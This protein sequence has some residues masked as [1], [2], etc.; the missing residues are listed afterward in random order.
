VDDDQAAVLANEAADLQHGDAVAGWAD[1]N[2][3]LVVALVREVEDRVAQ[4]VSEVLIRNSVFPRGGEDLERSIGGLT[5]RSLLTA[6]SMALCGGGPG[7]ASQ[8]WRT[9]PSSSASISRSSRWPVGRG[10]TRRRPTPST[11]TASRC[12]MSWRTSR[13]PRTAVGSRRGRYTQF[14][15]PRGAQA[16]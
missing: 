11:R 10:A 13:T 7:S 1:G 12:D 2:G 15:R 4:R 6:A 8:P 14:G 9:T 3:E 5:T 16:R